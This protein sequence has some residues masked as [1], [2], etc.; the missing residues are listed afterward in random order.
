[1]A[2]EEIEG[3]EIRLLLDAVYH[4]Y[5]YDFRQYARASLERRIRQHV[6]ETGVGGIAEL[7]APVIRDEAAFSA[8]ARRFSTSVTEMFRDPFV[9]RAVQER[10]LPTLATFPFVKIWAAG[11]A[12]GEEA[13]SLA[14]VLRESGL[15][16]RSTLYATDFNDANLRRA[17]SAVYPSDRMREFTRNYQKSGGT[18]SFA[19]YYQ[20]SADAAVLDAGVRE[21]VTFA[22]HNLATDQV[23]GEM[24]LV[25]CRNVLIYFD[26]QLR[27]R[28]LRLFTESLV[29]GGFLVLGTREEL[30]FSAVADAYDVVDREARIYRRRGT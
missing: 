14:I 11:C 3:L 10:V 30:R 29:H 20:A 27:D 12:T 18:R 26:A 5:G 21:Q 15:R 24:H 9:Y 4:R 23:F 13:Y 28:A 2:P 25:F 1:M 17:R 22:N 7:I 16:G 8:L 6:A 19:D